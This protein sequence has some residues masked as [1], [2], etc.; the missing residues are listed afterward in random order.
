VQY[1]VT[2]LDYILLDRVYGDLSSETLRNFKLVSG[3]VGSITTEEVRRLI[4]HNYVV[5]SDSIYDAR[6]VYKLQLGT[7]LD[8]FLME[9]I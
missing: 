7:N 4:P 6:I 8:R 5:M 3:T 1:L 9:G 2:I